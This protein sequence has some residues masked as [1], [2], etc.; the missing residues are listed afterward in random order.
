[1]KYKSSGEGEYLTKKDYSK[2]IIFSLQDFH[3]KG[4]LL[5]EVI[6]PPNTKQRSHYHD[7]Q[8]E[9]WYILQGEAYFYLNNIEYFV[10][11]GDALIGSPKEAHFV[12]NKSDKELHI[13]VFKIDMPEDS[14]DTQWSE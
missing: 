2:K 3:S 11:P 12:W 10:K 14:D 4:H 6:I 7:K 13:L 1:M 8:T 9:V 5:Q